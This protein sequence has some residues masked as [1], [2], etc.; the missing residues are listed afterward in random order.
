MIIQS[1]ELHYENAQNINI[2]KD[3]LQ[4]DNKNIEFNEN[5]NEEENNSFE[6][7]DLND[8]DNMS[9]IHDTQFNSFIYKD[10]LGLRTTKQIETM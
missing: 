1:Q 4:K 8:Y 7:A 10:L 5:E 9:L 6:E 2:E 3:H